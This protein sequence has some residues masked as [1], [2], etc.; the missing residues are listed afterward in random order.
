MPMLLQSTT[1]ARDYYH[2]YCCDK[3]FDGLLLARDYYDDYYY[4]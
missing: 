2:D 1:H 4:D 3:Y